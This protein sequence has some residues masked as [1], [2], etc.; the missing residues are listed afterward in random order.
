MANNFVTPVGRIV[1]GSVFKKLT[2]DQRGNA[3]QFKD[4]TPRESTYIGLAIAKNHAGYAGLMAFIDAEAKAV[5]PQ[6]QTTYNTFNW[7]IYDGDDP[8]HQEQEG[9]A[10]HSVLRLTSNF[11]ITIYAQ[12]GRTVLT[13]PTSVKCGDYVEALISVASNRDTK[14]PGLYLNFHA[15]RLVGYGTEIVSVDYSKH[16]ADRPAQMPQGA[17]PSP[18]PN[19]PMPQAPPP[20]RPSAP[21]APSAPQM[22]PKANGIPYEAF[23]AEGWTIEELRAEGYIQ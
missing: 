13:D 22:T 23:I 15:V 20:R 9:F 5:W 16:F 18:I 11:G 2:K 7:K 8:K 14:E 19:G 4:K 21:S 12:D 1:Q 3:L 17:S 10:G 6:G